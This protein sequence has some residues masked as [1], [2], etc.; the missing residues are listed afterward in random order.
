MTIIYHSILNTKKCIFLILV[1][2]NVVFHRSVFVT[3]DQNEQKQSLTEFRATVMDT[4]NQ[5]SVDLCKAG[6]IHVTTS[7]HSC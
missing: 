6:F 4:F 7:K 5:M 1:Q 2:A 3:V